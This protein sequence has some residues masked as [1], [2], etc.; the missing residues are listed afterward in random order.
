MCGREGIG[1]T[2][3]M[4]RFQGPLGDGP[5]RVSGDRTDSPH[6]V[7]LPGLPQGRTVY[8]QGLWLLSHTQICLRESDNVFSASGAFQTKDKT[9]THRELCRAGG[10]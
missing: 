10:A 3:R 6:R 9:Y 7:R 8:L 1:W 4:P 2:A 5:S